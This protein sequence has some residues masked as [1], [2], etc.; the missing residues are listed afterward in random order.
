ME[1]LVETILALVFNVCALVVDVKARADAKRSKT[2]IYFVLLW[3]WVFSLSASVLLEM[4]YENGIQLSWDFWIT[5]CVLSAKYSGVVIICLIML[6]WQC[7]KSF[8][9]KLFGGLLWPTE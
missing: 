8:I 9:G 5:K 2:R 3:A 1:T 7:S 6:A 4:L